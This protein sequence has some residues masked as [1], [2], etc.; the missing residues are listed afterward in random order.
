MIKQNTQDLQYCQIWVSNYMSLISV[1][2]L[3]FNETK[4]Q[5]HIEALPI[6]NKDI[7]TEIRES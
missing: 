1:N 6:S 2:V 3:K 4:C 7:G 5:V